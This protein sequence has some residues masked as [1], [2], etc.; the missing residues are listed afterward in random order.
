MLRAW[1]SGLPIAPQT[2][3]WRSALPGQKSE[4]RGPAPQETTTRRGL[5]LCPETAARGKLHGTTPN[6]PE[7]LLGGNARSSRLVLVAFAL[8]RGRAAPP[9]F[10]GPGW[11]PSKSRLL[12]ERRRFQRRAVVV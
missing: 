7:W 1:P 12:A 10:L 11:T 2:T 8:W 4:F 6:R 9:R 3:A 5:P